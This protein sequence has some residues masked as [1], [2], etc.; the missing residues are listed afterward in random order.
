MSKPESEKKLITGKDIP[1]RRMVLNDIS[2]LPTDYSSTP[3]G[4]F[5]STTPGGMMH[6]VLCILYFSYTAVTCGYYT[7][8]LLYGACIRC[9]QKTGYLCGFFN[10]AHLQP[11]DFC[12]ATFQ[13]GLWSAACLHHASHIFN[14]EYIIKYFTFF[15]LIKVFKS[16]QYL[17]RYLERGTVSS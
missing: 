9:V 7:S 13:A 1:T 5:F 3:G 14:F 6:V 8:L 16:S 2:Q 17:A 15:C 11:C 12:L 10:M 4:T